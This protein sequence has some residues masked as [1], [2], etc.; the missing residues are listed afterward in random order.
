MLNEADSGAN[1]DLAS[2]KLR[3]ILDVIDSTENYMQKSYD[4]AVNAKKEHE[5]ICV[6][7]KEGVR[8]EIAQITVFTI[9]IEF[10]F[11]P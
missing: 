7:E 11:S 3:K 6:Q 5:A 1:I 9:S 8:G 2:S 4:E 10:L